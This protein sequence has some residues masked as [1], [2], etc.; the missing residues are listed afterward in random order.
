MSANR[1]LYTASRA[2]PILYFIPSSPPVRTVLLVAKAIDLELDLQLVDLSRNEHMQ[3]WF[4]ALNPQHTLPTLVEPDG[5]VLWDSH[6]IS[7]YLVGKYGGSDD[8]PLYPRDLYTRARIDQRLQ[9]DTGVLFQL[10]RRVFWPI[11]NENASEIDEDA[12]V[13]VHDAYAMLEAFLAGGTYLVG[14]HLTVA[15]LSVVT[16]VTQLESQVPLGDND[17]YPRILAWLDR[18]EE[19]PYFH[20]INT[21]NLR[22]VVRTLDRL[23]EQNR[24][25]SD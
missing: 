18:L 20:D 1:K 6:A 17:K 7:T 13:R 14:D 11:F 23:K 19:L 22:D 3:P 15:D 4:L 5:S 12:V 10:G 21:V 9:F 2:K 16:S 8:H 25:L 24:M